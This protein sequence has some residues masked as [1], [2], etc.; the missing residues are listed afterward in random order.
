MISL[1]I[2]G[3]FHV[4]HLGEKHETISCKS[5]IFVHY[6]VRIKT[7]KSHR[8]DL[9]LYKA[10]IFKA[11]IVSNPTGVHAFKLKLPEA[12]NVSRYI[13]LVTHTM[14]KKTPLTTWC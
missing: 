7:N 3:H 10:K 11:E 14:R 4:V 6:Y 9:L 2:T 5:N 1:I 13:A 8:S 12:V